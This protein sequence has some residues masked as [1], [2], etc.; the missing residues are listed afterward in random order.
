MVGRHPQKDRAEGRSPLGPAVGLPAARRTA[1]RFANEAG[2][3]SRLGPPLGKGDF[4]LGRDGEGTKRVELNAM[5][6]RQFIDFI[7]RKLEE[8]GVEKVIPEAELI[9]SHARRLIEQKLIHDAVEKMRDRIA[10]EAQQTDL[11]D[12][13]AD[14]V[15][16]VLEEQPE[17]SWDQAVAVVLEI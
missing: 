4:L 11:P 6:S 12:D 8:H 3:G 9:T 2:A 10:D 14:R 7:E 17:L 13:L 5:S 1:T 16:A 15:S